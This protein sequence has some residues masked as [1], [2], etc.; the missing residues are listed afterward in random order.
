M[1]IFVEFVKGRLTVANFFI[2]AV[3]IY[4]CAADKPPILGYFYNKWLETFKFESWRINFV[5][6]DCRS[7]WK[8]CK[9]LIRLCC[10]TNNLT[11]PPKKR[12]SVFYRSIHLN[13]II[14]FVVFNCCS[15]PVHYNRPVQINN[16]DKIKE[17]WQFFLLTPENSK[18]IHFHS[19]F[20][21]CK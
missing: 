16:F 10:K 13:F 20:Y 12:K 9:S 3:R 14:K 11:P 4:K 8:Q 2:V 19:L 18:I 6:L 5:L 1:S 17:V 15:S 7:W 21:F